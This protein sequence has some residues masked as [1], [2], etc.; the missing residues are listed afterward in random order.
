M[1]LEDDISK[2]NNIIFNKSA[3]LLDLPSSLSALKN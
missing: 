2:I 3:N 1:E